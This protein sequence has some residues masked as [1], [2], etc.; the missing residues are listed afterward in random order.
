MSNI[1]TILTQKTFIIHR[2]QRTSLCYKR[3]VLIHKRLAISLYTIPN[4]NL[5]NF[6][7]TEPSQ[8]VPTKVTILSPLSEHYQ[9]ISKT[10]ID[11]TGEFWLEI[12]SNNST[13]I[14][15]SIFASVHS[16]R[17]C[18]YHENQCSY[19]YGCFFR[20]LINLKENENRNHW[21]P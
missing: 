1:L 20:N 19:Y 12:M 9:M 14:V 8:P 13:I 6:I 11:C 4:I 5:E 18:L 7:W 2:F 21:L 16:F 17:A 10:K 3:Y 15:K